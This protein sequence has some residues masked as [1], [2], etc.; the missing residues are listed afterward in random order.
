LV[1]QMEKLNISGKIMGYLYR[2]TVSV[3]FV[4]GFRDR[5]I[6]DQI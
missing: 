3:F 4:A 2:F 1:T 6:L 5:R